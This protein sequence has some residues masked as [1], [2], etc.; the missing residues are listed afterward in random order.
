MPIVAQNAPGSTLIDVLAAV[1]DVFSA[2]GNATPIMVGKKYLTDKI[3]SPPRVIFVPETGR[4]KIG[5][6][7][8]LG[9]SAGCV[10]SCVVHIRAKESGDDF[11]RFRAAYALMDLVVDCIQTV[12]TGNIEWTGDLGDASPTDTDG[13]GCELVF[14]FLYRR[15]I[16]HNAALWALT[17]WG[18]DTSGPRP[19]PPPGVPSGGNTITPTTTP[20]P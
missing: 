14:A 17:G 6:I 18:S 1:R 9:N 5:P 2:L 4:G 7:F 12:A 3:G 13:P 10:H 15:D 16:A 11:N 20:V 19:A 8:E